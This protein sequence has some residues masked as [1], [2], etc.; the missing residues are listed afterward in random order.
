MQDLRCDR[1]P[2]CSQAEF[3]EPQNGSEGPL[4]PPSPCRAPVGL[5][6]HRPA[7]Q[8]P[9]ASS[10]SKAGPLLA[11][12]KFP[13]AK[14]NQNLN[15]SCASGQTAENCRE[16]TRGSGATSPHPGPRPPHRLQPLPSASTLTG[17]PR[18]P[19]VP[20]HRRTN[21]QHNPNRHSSSAERRLTTAPRP[22]PPREAG[23]PPAQR[24]AP[25]RHG[26]APAEHG[27][28]PGEGR[29]ALAGGAAALHRG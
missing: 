28:P 29:S 3:P 7:A 2:H 14:N 26:G 24:S 8:G 17:A 11:C 1:T 27:P 12:T 16:P 21:T 18:P 5:P 22:P 4:Q 9:S 13:T 23:A 6:P 15:A 19:R 25:W 20:S 10:T